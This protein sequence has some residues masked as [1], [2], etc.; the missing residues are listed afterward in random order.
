MDK[1]I[2]PELIEKVNKDFE[3][4]ISQDKS[5]NALNEKLAAGQAKYE[6]A[7]KYAES[8]GNARAKAFKDQISSEVLPEGK[9]HY[10]IGS[11]LMTDSLT[12][13]H[14]MVAE[15]AAGVQK[16]YNEKAGISLKALK[17]DVDEDRIDGFV[18]RL[19]SEEVFDDVAWIMQE[20]VV[21]HSRSVVDDTIKKN[22]E[23]QHKAGLTAK[24]TRKAAPR[25]CDWCTDLEGDYTY[26]NVPR[27]VFQRHDNCKCTVDYDGKRLKAHDSGRHD[28]TFRDP[29]EGRRSSGSSGSGRSAKDRKDWHGYKTKEE[30][31]N[32]FSKHRLSMSASNSNGET[33]REE[34]GYIDPEKKDS[35]IAYYREQIRN[36]KV[37][38][39]IVIENDG[40][41]VHFVGN[42]E[43]VD[44]F[45]TNLDKARVL[46]NH[47]GVEEYRS[48]GKDDFETMQE[49]QTAIYDLCDSRYNYKVEVLKDIN[50]VSYSEYY[51]RAAGDGDMQDTVMKLLSE[52]GYI[53]YDKR[54]A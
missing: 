3:R 42:S 28:H 36:E 7:Y 45:D 49:C 34:V 51:R 10:N 8:V 20:P 16:S 54:R 5:V 13:D 12:T 47:T 53:K 25:C 52:D 17:A 37:E 48:F 22:A 24:V 9:M 15:Y 30:Y 39:A 43:G 46:H 41:V 33:I 27:E 31:V 18:Q 50:E 44:I 2:A 19:A 14:N 29:D 35:A 38:H 40:K 4:N 32:R 11:R 23:F 26:P 1:D 21:T 6:D